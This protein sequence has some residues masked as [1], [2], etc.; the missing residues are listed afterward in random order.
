[1]LSWFN[2]NNERTAGI[3]DRDN[4]SD[5]DYDRTTLRGVVIAVKKI[6]A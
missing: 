2:T 6:S 3:L 5:H 4:G 1:M